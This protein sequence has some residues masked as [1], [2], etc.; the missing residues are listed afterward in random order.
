MP[1]FLNFLPPHK[2]DKQWSTSSHT[3]AQDAAV[4]HIYF[5]MKQAFSVHTPHVLFTPVSRQ[6]FPVAMERAPSLSNHPTPPTQTSSATAGKME[7]CRSG[8]TAAEF[9]WAWDVHSPIRITHTASRT[10]NTERMWP[11]IVLLDYSMTQRQ[12]LITPPSDAE[13]FLFTGAS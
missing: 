1:F 10:K 4:T 3:A 2:T 12:F 11:Y 5:T 9:W 6:P 7:A 8:G 13:P